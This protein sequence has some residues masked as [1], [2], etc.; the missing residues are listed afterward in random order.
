MNFTVKSITNGF[1]HPKF[2]RIMVQPN[3][4]NRMELHKNLCKKPHLYTPT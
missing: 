1:P 3:H 2:S 4:N